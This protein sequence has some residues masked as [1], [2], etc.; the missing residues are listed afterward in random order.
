MTGADWPG[1][2]AVQR[3]DPG[4]TS[5]GSPVSLETP[6]CSGPRQLNQ[7]RTSPAHTSDEPA[8]ASRETAAS[9]IATVKPLD[10]RSLARFGKSDIMSFAHSITPVWFAN[11]FFLCTAGAGEQQN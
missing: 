11:C 2:S 7:P 9:A 4:A 5:D 3:A 10:C 1:K 6:V 8:R